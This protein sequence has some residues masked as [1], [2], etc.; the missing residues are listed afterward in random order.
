MGDD[1][2]LRSRPPRATAPTTAERLDAHRDGIL[3][4]WEDAAREHAKSRMLEHPILMDNVPDL[5]DRLVFTMRDPH[6]APEDAARPADKA[7]TAHALD[8]L[9]RGFDLEEVVEEYA[10]LRRCTLEALADAPLPAQEGVV[11]NH[12]FDAAISRAVTAYAAARERT[13]RGLERIS[14]AGATLDEVDALVSAL[15]RVLVETTPAVD[16]ASVL[17]VE[18]DRLRVRAAI[19]V[20]E[21]S[22]RDYEIGADAGAEGRIAATRRPLELRSG[23]TDPLVMSEALRKRGVRALY[24]VPL[25]D[26]ETLVGV[27]YIGSTIAHELSDEDKLIFRSMATRTT[28]LIARAQTVE[29][30]RR[31]REELERR[32]AELQEREDE[33]ARAGAFRDRLLAVVGH[34]LRNPLS[35][36]RLGAAAALATAPPEGAAALERIIRAARRMERIIDDLVDVARARFG[37]GLPL[38]R[39]AADLRDVVRGVVE[40]YRTTHAGR[41]IELEA[42]G[43]TRAELDPDRVAQLASNLV[44]NALRYGDA[45]APVRVEVRGDDGALTLRVE[46]AGRPIAPEL[47]PNLFDP[48]RRGE[49]PGAPERQRSE[50]QGLGLGLFIVDAIVRAHGGSI[51]VDSSAERG[52]TFTVRLPRAPEASARATQG[53]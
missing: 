43:D 32:T 48:F 21:D 10:I 5:L 31:A 1:H 49:V 28:G 8:R 23:A 18:G 17:L 26:R 22:G 50:T 44:Q 33:L 11:L 51:D 53:G 34:D 27:A 15:L 42:A 45:V 3:A 36:V 20:E 35:A 16:A 52:T 13:L 47:L 37:G 7:A 38:R 25:L 14:E 19:G 40:E 2:Q 4:A 41:Q 6:V 12:V 39:A 46:N 24:G 29:R 30:E 9:E